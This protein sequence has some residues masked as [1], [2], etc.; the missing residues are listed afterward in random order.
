MEVGEEDNKQT[1]GYTPFFLSA[2]DEAK[3]DIDVS[4]VFDQVI[5]SDK[6]YNIAITGPYSSGKS[7]FVSSYKKNNT[8]FS[9][10]SIDVSLASFQVD[11][12]D[13]QGGTSTKLEAFKFSDIE[14]SII[15]QIIYK[16]P[17]ST[18]PKSRFSKLAN[19]KDTTEWK[20][21]IFSSLWLLSVFYIF[22]PKSYIFIDPIRPI[23]G[24]YLEFFNI[25][26]SLIMLVGCLLG[27][28]FI[29]KYLKST[30]PLSKI[31]YLNPTSAEIS[32]FSE[33]DSV[34]NRT[35]DELVYFF[36]SSQ[37]N[38]V[39][40]EDLERLNK[41]EIFT[42]LR[43]I[44]IIL[45]N[46]DAVREQHKKGIKFIYVTKDDC[47]SA[48]ERTKF[49]DFILPII[50]IIHSNNSYEKI[51]ELISTIKDE[52]LSRKF[53]RD[54]TVFISDMRVLQNIVNEFYF[55]RKLVNHDL[56]LSDDN[57]FALVL[58]KN[59]FPVEFEP[60]QEHEISL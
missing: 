50:P 9:N 20:A 22:N 42:K 14:K 57:L 17:S 32:F 54:V 4:N 55:Y 35:L 31:S 26:L 1:D 38:K 37:Y 2:T 13:V 48:T 46:S 43:E 21:Y 44:N 33:S 59:M 56:S 18:I 58:C 25:G 8:E 10:S 51:R 28:A 24:R 15:Q 11:E 30:L 19:S 34:L 45:N 7:S 41:P 16:V 47:F 36:S 27:I 49:F 3:I 23:L 29:F 40:F 53:L 12:M 60:G 5:A 39:I 6:A 52:K